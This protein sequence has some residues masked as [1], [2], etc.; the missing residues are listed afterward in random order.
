MRGLIQQTSAAIA[1]LPHVTPGD[2]LLFS[3]ASNGDVDMDNFLV[4][5]QLFATVEKDKRMV[6]NLLRNFEDAVKVEACFSIAIETIRGKVLNEVTKQ[7]RF[8]TMSE[9]ITE[10]FEACLGTSLASE[11]ITLPCG[12]EKRFNISGGVLEAV[13][14]ATSTLIV[15]RELGC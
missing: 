15:I 8:G 6:F 7:G 4:D 13:G 1:S 14:D 10:S 9:Q 12:T 5:E 2:E 11:F 3:D